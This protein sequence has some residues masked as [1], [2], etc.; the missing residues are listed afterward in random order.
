VGARAGAGPEQTGGTSS[1]GHETSG[2]SSLIILGFFLFSFIGPGSS[3]RLDIRSVQTRVA[4]PKYSNLDLDP[5]P[6]LF[7]LSKLKLVCEG[8]PFRRDKV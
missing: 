4:D 7:K 2:Q 5:D 1:A 3:S 8:I 6:F